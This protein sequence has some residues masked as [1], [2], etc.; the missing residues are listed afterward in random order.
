[1][2]ARLT[3]LAVQI[4]AI[5]VDKV[6][7]ALREVE[8][9]AQRA[10][11]GVA[12]ATS[13]A[14]PA[15]FAASARTMA[16]GLGQV[17]ESGNLA[18][19]GMKQ[20]VIQGSQMALLFGVGGP[21]VGGIGLVALG[22]FNMFQRTR[23]EIAETARAA[24][25]ELRSL[26]LASGNELLQEL[27]SGDVT[28]DPGSPEA[29]GI[30]GSKA[31]LAELQR[32]I[33]AAGTSTVRNPTTGLTSTA[34]RADSAWL[35]E[36]QKLITFLGN[37][38]GRYRRIKTRV[39]ELAAAEVERVGIAAREDARAKASASTIAA[40]EKA[41]EAEARLAA[42]LA[43]AFDQAAYHLRG[44]NVAEEVNR[45]IT[46]KANEE[47]ERQ[48]RE[49]HR[50][51]SADY[52]NPDTGTGSFVLPPGGLQSDVREQWMEAVD[53]QFADMGQQIGAT[54]AD[55]ISAGLMEAFSGGGITGGFKAI[56]KSIL[57]GLGSIFSQMGQSLLK[58]G[59]VMKGLL[60]ALSNP[61]TSGAAAI[62]AGVAL[63]ALGGLL[64]GIAQGRAGA[65]GGGGGSFREPYSYARQGDLV[66]IKLVGTQKSKASDIVP[67]TNVTQLVVIGENDPAARASLRRMI[68][69]DKRRG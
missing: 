67:N 62:A 34:S 38:E 21:I 19:A 66:Q 35:Q 48:R 47:R 54:F 53:S 5:G 9:E 8:S 59:L 20:I 3:A 51:R 16:A 49:F 23:R 60:P 11:K 56:G 26:S 30:G 12:N 39:D 32:K 27:Y 64:G 1:M 45:S 41:R 42:D 37:V 14:G 55:G 44:L 2:A 17:A 52:L 6:K 50:Q 28:A 36:E 43:F 31:R 7:R 13:T 40:R 18:G 68:D 46:K 15:K 61:F 4:E 69:G 22:I 58:Y 63:M 29:L 25:A 33:A 65:G 24:R 10:G 57:S